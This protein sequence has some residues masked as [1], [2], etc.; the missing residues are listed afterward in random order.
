[1]NVLPSELVSILRCSLAAG[2]RSVAVAAASADYSR[3]CRAAS[4]RVRRVGDLL[5][6]GLVDQALWEAWQTPVLTDHV[7]ALEFPERAE[8]RAFCVLHQLIIADDWDVGVVR[9]L[10]VLEAQGLPRGHFFYDQFHSAMSRQ[11][12]SRAMSV[13]GLIA[14]L[15][16]QDAEVRN[17]LAR[18]KEAFP[19]LALLTGG[20]WAEFSKS[21][22]F[23]SAQAGFDAFHS[24]AEGPIGVGLTLAGISEP[25]VPSWAINRPVVPRLDS[26]QAISATGDGSDNPQPADNPVSMRLSHWTSA[27]PNLL[28]DNP[29]TTYKRRPFLA[30]GAVAL[31]FLLLLLVLLLGRPETAESQPTPVA[32]EVEQLWRGLRQLEETKSLLLSIKDQSV[33]RERLAEMQV[34]LTTISQMLETGGVTAFPIRLEPPPWAQPDF[35]GFLEASSV[36]RQCRLDWQDPINLEGGSPVAWKP[37]LELLVAE[38]EAWRRVAAFFSPDPVRSEASLTARAAFLASLQ[39]PVLAVLEGRVGAGG[40]STKPAGSPRE[41]V[42]LV[43]A[44]GL[45]ERAPDWL[46]TWGETDGDLA[47]FNQLQGTNLPHWLIEEKNAAIAALAAADDNEAKDRPDGP[48]PDKP[49]PDDVDDAQAG[50]VLED[51]DAMDATAPVFIWVLSPDSLNVSDISGAD[52]LPVERKMVLRV[53]GV[54]AEWIHL[55]SW[56]VQKDYLKDDTLAFASEKRSLLNQ[57]FVFSGRRLARIPKDLNINGGRIVAHSASGRLLFDLRLVAAPVTTSLFPSWSE[58]KVNGR[59][60]PSI[61][62]IQNKLRE[63][64]MVSVPSVMTRFNFGAGRARYS[65]RGNSSKFPLSA[66]GV[67]SR[68]GMKATVDDWYETMLVT[69]VR[70]SE[71][72]EEM[73]AELRR[74]KEDQDERRLVREDDNGR[75]SIPKPRTILELEKELKREQE[76]LARITMDIVEFETELKSKNITDGRYVTAVEL[77]LADKRMIPLDLFTMEVF[78]FE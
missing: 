42:E 4:V 29:R 37:S 6:A 78:G 33:A 36:W 23:T 28:R 72:V 45:M 69:Q 44:L 12:V 62:K 19:R 53:G 9:H 47:A 18:M 74:V 27:W 10:V 32:M 17:E 70:K 71:K 1:M 63:A 46:E 26:P 5:A 22:T 43:N 16:P 59:K 73:Q 54:A 51:A 40:L 14:R 7:A 50:V 31:V 38:D 65:L 2:V 25:M 66:D 48:P 76:F 35:L 67:V 30:I 58:I 41:W 21:K 64:C 11:E 15:N 39:A 52:E 49:P 55:R 61:T 60:K 20:P 34:S 57:C 24:R 3:L 68:A 13:L 8:W 56:P 77:M 75:R